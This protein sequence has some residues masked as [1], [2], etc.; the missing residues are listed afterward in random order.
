MSGPDAETAAEGTDRKRAEDHPGLRRCPAMSSGSKPGP[1][2]TGPSTVTPAAWTPEEPYCRPSSA[3]RARTPAMSEKRLTYCD[4]GPGVPPVTG[5][6]PLPRAATI[7]ARR[8]AASSA[9]T[10]CRLRTSPPS[11]TR[12]S[13]PCARLPTSGT[14]SPRS[15]RPPAGARSRPPQP[16]PH[17]SSTARRPAP[18]ASAT[19]TARARAACPWL[20]YP[21]GDVTWQRQEGIQSV[22][23]VC[24]TWGCRGAAD[25]RVTASRPRHRAEGHRWSPAGTTIAPT[26]GAHSPNPRQRPLT[27]RYQQPMLTA[28]CAA[29]PPPL[30]PSRPPPPLLPPTSRRHLHWSLAADDA[31]AAALAGRRPTARSRP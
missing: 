15:K 16:S 5:N 3:I 10:T 14:R 9:P 13:A 17:P 29:W 25:S 2:A 27:C 6:V 7:G 23:R 19:R 4:S 11:P 18:A 30:S 24:P 21:F 31:E 20:R 1:G 8:A 12:S 22:P 26:R 28:C